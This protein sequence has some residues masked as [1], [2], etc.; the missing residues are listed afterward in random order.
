MLILRPNLKLLS[1]EIL[2]FL[3]VSD[4]WRHFE[5][6]FPIP[7]W[8]KS[9]HHCWYQWFQI[10]FQNSNQ[11]NKSSQTSTHMLC[12]V[13]VSISLLWPFGLQFFK[14]HS[15]IKVIRWTYVACGYSFESS[16]QPDVDSVTQFEVTDISRGIEIFPNRR[17]MTSNQSFVSNSQLAKIATSLLMSVISKLP[18]CTPYWQALQNEYLHVISF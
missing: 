7:H 13:R 10:R 16:C 15:P 4:H 6:S 1:A 12:H 17:Q 3:P 8:P 5:V 11:I 14:G 9:Q 2:R 18:E